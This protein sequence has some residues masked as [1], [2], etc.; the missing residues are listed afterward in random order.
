MIAASVWSLLLPGI[1]FSEQQN[2]PPWLPAGIGFLMGG[3]F[4]LA[5]DKLLPHQHAQSGI[6]EGPVS[7]LKKTTKLIFAVTLHNFPEGMAVG[8][9]FALAGATGSDVSLAAAFALAI[10]IA[11]QNIPEGAVISLPLKEE[12]F[13]KK[14]AFFTA[15]CRGGRA[16]CGAY[17]RGNSLYHL[18]YYTMGAFVCGGRNDIC[19]N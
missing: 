18:P 13:S 14:K 17:K 6:I 7:R 4:L 16:S 10:G 19:G 11:I 3:F 5:L 2:M 15:H 9:A 12:G 8:L 1:E